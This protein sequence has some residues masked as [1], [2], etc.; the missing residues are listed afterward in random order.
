MFKF[1]RKKKVTQSKCKLKSTKLLY[2]KEYIIIPKV[3]IE[4]GMGDE[5]IRNFNILITQ[6]NGRFNTLLDLIAEAK[7]KNPKT[8]RYIKSPDWI[9]STELDNGKLIKELIYR[10]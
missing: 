5:W 10:S 4:S 2:N 9:K 6:Y 7:L 3:L 8:G 1:L